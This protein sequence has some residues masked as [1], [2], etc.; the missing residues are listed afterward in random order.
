[1]KSTTK[2]RKKKIT[3]II[4]IILALPIV[5]FALFLLYA[6][7]ADYNPKKEIVVYES[8]EADKLK[9][10][11]EINIMLWNIGYCGLGADMDFFYDGGEQVRT[12][13]EQTEKNL[14]AVKSFLKEKSSEIDFFLLQE[15]DKKAK[16]S[17]KI[18]QHE[19]I[20]ETLS[21]YKGF[22]GINYKVFFIPTPPTKPYGKV[23]AGLATYSKYNP[24]KATR[25]PFPGNYSW[26]M[27]LFML[28][29]CFLENRY[30]LDN[31]KELIIINT[32]NSAYDDGTLKQQQNEYLKKHILQEYQNGNYVIVGGDWNQCPPNFKP[33]FD[34]F[35]MD[36]ETR[37]NIA[38]DYL[39]DWKW[40]FQNKTP[41]NRRVSG[42]YD[43]TKTLT[44]MIDFFVISPNI[45]EISIEAIDFNFQ[46]SDHQPVVAKLKLK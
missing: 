17:Y 19:E 10:D 13:K 23:L 6:T 14:K 4:L 41:T 3:K 9:S 28:D 44:T 31:G 30:I 46:N 37:T 35:T 32:H 40:V 24:T 33:D 1:M 26:P 7:L 16:R 42:I 18:N 12:S 36:N 5:L 21:N 27:G 45:N 2:N 38:N 8:N 15:V 22:F 43:K 39:I 29:R 11:M 20:L 34:G 25:F